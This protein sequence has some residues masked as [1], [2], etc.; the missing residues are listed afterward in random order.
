MKVFNE[1]I[2]RHKKH[3]IQI[4]KIMQLGLISELF[5]I[6]MIIRDELKTVEGKIKIGF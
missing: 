4:S 6:K 1:V 3:N 2:R 5:Q